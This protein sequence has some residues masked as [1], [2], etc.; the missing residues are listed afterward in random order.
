MYLKRKVGRNTSTNGFD[1]YAW[2]LSDTHLPF[3]IILSLTS[4]GK[5]VSES[6]RN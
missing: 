3:A 5:A 4:P 6:A 1:L 2:I